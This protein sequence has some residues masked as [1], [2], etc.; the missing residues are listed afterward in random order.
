MGSKIFGY[1]RRIEL[2]ITKHT[3][4]SKYYGQPNLAEFLSNCDYIVNVLPCT[5]ETTGLLNGD[6]LKNCEGIFNSYV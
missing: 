4:L 5:L 3:Y 6:V 2:D 1:G